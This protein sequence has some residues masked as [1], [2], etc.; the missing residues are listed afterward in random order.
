MCK[1]CEFNELND[2]IVVAN[3]FVEVKV[4]GRTMDK[5]ILDV[6]FMK[7]EDEDTVIMYVGYSMD[8]L[9]DV[10]KIRLPIAF[11]PFCGRAL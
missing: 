11:C 7:N 6:T 9:D 10:A 5:H 8:D 3:D 4:G 1:F 2:A